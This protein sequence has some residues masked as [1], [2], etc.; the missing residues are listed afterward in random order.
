MKNK[1]IVY[2]LYAM[3]R[4]GIIE[5]HQQRELLKQAA[6]RI[7]EPD[8]KIKQLETELAEMEQMTIE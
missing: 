2:A 4:K 6:N 7:A 5:N 1:D 8:I 3:A